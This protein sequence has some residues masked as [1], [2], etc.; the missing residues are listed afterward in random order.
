MGLTLDVKLTPDDDADVHMHCSLL[1]LMKSILHAR[2][3][4][5]DHCLRVFGH[6]SYFARMATWL[7]IFW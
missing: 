3:R 6:M 7:M 4:A 1:L 5:S 2:R